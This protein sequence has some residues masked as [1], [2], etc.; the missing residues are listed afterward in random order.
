MASR[1]PQLL[2]TCVVGQTVRVRGRAGTQRGLLLSVDATTGE[3]EFMGNGALGKDGSESRVPLDTVCPLFAWEQTAPEY[4]GPADER[5]ERFKEQGNQLFKAKDLVAA[6]ARYSL[7]LKALHDDAPLVC[8]ARCL[9]KPAK[10]GGAARG[11]LV[12]A[13]DAE[14][15]DVEYERA[16][17]VAG[18]GSVSERL[19][20]L[21][22]Q[23]EALERGEVT[24][25]AFDGAPAADE[26][27]D[28]VPRA[29][30]CVVVIPHSI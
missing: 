3:V 10:S 14:S 18:G 4:D 16:G 25:A 20:Q 28:G 26:D 5:A 29:R 21:L 11:A 17:A 1:A 19:P 2:P 7:A 30:V 9:V 23:A 22:A 6:L 13:T 8:G 27:E 12:L 24:A 15:V